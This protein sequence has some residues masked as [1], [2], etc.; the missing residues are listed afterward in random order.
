MKSIIEIINEEIRS[1]DE[2]SY[3]AQGVADKFSEKF[4]IYPDDAN[5]KTLDYMQ[6][7]KEKPFGYAKGTPVYKNPEN[8]NNFDADVRA[9]SD[10]YGNLYVAQSNTNIIHGDIADDIVLIPA[11]TRIYDN[12]DFLL[13][14]RV[15]FTRTFGFSDTTE[16]RYKSYKTL[17]PHIL[18]L[19][20]TV[21]KHNPQYKF[22]P[23]YYE[24]I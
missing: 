19:L 11:S 15:G 21:K 10:K 20:D 1:F 22:I 18:E 24:N 5:V 9:L 7:K 13:L 6:R 16:T 14:H 3:N 23:E 12:D 17:A 4:H 8:L 2:G